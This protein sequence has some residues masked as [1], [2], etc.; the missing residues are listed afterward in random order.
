MCCVS[1]GKVRDYRDTGVLTG[2][3]FVS[4]IGCSQ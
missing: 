3:V 1:V 2:C 4:P